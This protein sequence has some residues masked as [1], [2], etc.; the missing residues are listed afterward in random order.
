MKG[1]GGCLI[2]SAGKGHRKSLTFKNYVTNALLKKMA[3]NMPS[4]LLMLHCPTVYALL[5][6]TSDNFVTYALLRNGF[7]EKKEMYSRLGRIYFEL[8][9][10]Q[11]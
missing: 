3:K 7:F 11:S 8:Y 9:T 1:G 4:L 10:V 6:L 2:D 5:S